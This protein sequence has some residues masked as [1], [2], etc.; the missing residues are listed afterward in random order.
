MDVKKIGN[1]IFWGG[2]IVAAV[3]I[4]AVSAGINFKYG[5]MISWLFAAV[6]AVFGVSEV[7]LPAIR[8]RCESRFHKRLASGSA[9]TL[10]LISFITSISFLQSSRQEAEDESRGT[11]SNLK[12]KQHDISVAQNTL[13]IDLARYKALSEKCLEQQKI[14]A[15]NPKKGWV[16][17]DCG[18]ANEAKQALDRTRSDM[19]QLRR[20]AESSAA[21]IIPPNERIYYDLASF[22]WGKPAQWE[23]GI[24]LLLALMVAG[25]GWVYFE[26]LSHVFEVQ[27]KKKA[28]EMEE[29][30]AEAKR[31][32]KL[33]MRK[34][35]LEAELEAR[36]IQRQI[37]EL[38]EPTPDPDPPKTVKKKPKDKPVKER[39][40]NVVQMVKPEPKGSDFTLA[41][42]LVSTGKVKPTISG[43]KTDAKRFGLFIGNDKAKLFLNRLCNMGVIDQNGSKGYKLSGKSKG[44]GT[45]D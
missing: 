23:A 10:V 13:N 39:P 4:I 22:F 42:K 16:K 40:D 1:S 19:G 8:L 38:E 45:S 35:E 30:R 21:E 14:N 18:L 41:K 28:K 25:L 6:F 5:M 27:E 31:K 24:G 2:A 32:E 17:R 34:E 7:L 29:A 43:L 20:S 36:T 12:G 26:T 15:I 3:S 33:R 37:K 44:E 9:I 11:I